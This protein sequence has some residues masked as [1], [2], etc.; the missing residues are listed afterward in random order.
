M[1]PPFDILKVF[2]SGTLNWIEAATTLDDAKKRIEQIMQL[3]A[4]EYI[5]YDQ[6]T[7]NKVSIKP[8]SYNPSSPLPD[9]LSLES[10]PSKLTR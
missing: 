3:H 7:G 9:P 5:I 1:L 8:A 6:Q 4:G 10:A 2:P